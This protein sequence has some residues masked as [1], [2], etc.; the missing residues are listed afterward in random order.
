MDSNPLR[1]F[2]GV[3]D[4]LAHRLHCTALRYELTELPVA[5]ENGVRLY[6]TAFGL[7]YAAFGFAIDATGKWFF[8]EANTAGQYGFLESNT[9]APISASLADLLAGGAS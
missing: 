3:T 2:G 8:L 4:R 7:A 9:G 1:R 5:V 6:M